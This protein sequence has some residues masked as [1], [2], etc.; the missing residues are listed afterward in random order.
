MKKGSSQPPHFIKEWRKHRGLTQEQ[1]ANRVH[2]T[3]N[4]VSKVESFNR[5]YTQQTLPLFAEALGC[6]AADLLRAPPS[7][8]RPESEFEY[9]KRILTENQLKQAVEVIRVMF[10]RKA[11]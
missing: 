5:P 10:S 6:D 7:P 11:S 2:M 3:R 8:D 9:Y 1:V 4:N